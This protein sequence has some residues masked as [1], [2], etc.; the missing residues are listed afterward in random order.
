MVS[1]NTN[2]LVGTQSETTNT[3]P[4]THANNF[5][6]WSRLTLA[7]LAPVVLEKLGKALGGNVQQL[8]EMLV[9][10]RAIASL[11]SGSA[12]MPGGSSLNDDFQGSVIMTE[13]G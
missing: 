4:G 7:K 13:E 12:R 5:F 6:G 1:L 8:T 11:T 10:N 2:S 3:T 9:H